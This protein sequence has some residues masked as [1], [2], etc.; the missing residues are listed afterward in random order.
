MQDA[1]EADL[2]TEMFRVG[3][4]LQERF[5]TRLEEQLEKHLFVLPDKGVQRVWDAEHQVIVVDGQQLLLAS[6]QPFITGVSLAFRTMAVSTRVIKKDLMSAAV[7]LIA[8]STQRG[9]PTAFDRTE[10]LHLRPGE[11]LLKAIDESSA[12]LADNISHLP[13]WL[14]HRRAFS[15]GAAV[16]EKSDT[17]IWSSGFT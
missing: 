14:F 13:G 5:C 3:S 1:H 10:H 11:V 16:L 17:V 9:R 7:A 8:V 2:R 12:G 4:N 6:R 15:G